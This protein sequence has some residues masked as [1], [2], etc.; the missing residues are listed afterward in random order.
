MYLGHLIRDGEV[1]PTPEKIDAVLGYPKP[2]SNKQVNSFLGLTSYFRKYIENFAAIA[3]P[4][5]DLLRKD[6]QFEFNESHKG[7]FETLKLKL[8]N[9]PVLKY[10]MVVCPLKYILIPLPWP[11]RL[12]CCS[13]IVMDYTRYTI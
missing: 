3:K 13:Y 8:S 6:A 10:I 12:F 5:T 1:R 2:I 4:L 11:I 7:A 9:D